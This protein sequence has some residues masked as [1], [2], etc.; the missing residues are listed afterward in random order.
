MPVDLLAHLH[1][2]EEHVRLMVKSYG[3]AHLNGGDFPRFSQDPFSLKDFR[4]TELRKFLPRLGVAVLFWLVGSYVNNVSQAWLQANMAG[5]YES[6]WGYS[7]ANFQDAQAWLKKNQPAVYH[8]RWHDTLPNE[9]IA[10]AP[11]AMQKYYQNETVTLFDLVFLYLPE[12]PSSGPADFFAGAPSAVGIIRFAVFPGPMSLRWTYL[13]RAIMVWGCLWYARAI[14]IIVTPLPN[15]Y[16]QCVPESPFPY[17]IWL[18]ALA[19]MPGAGLFGF[20]E[21]TCQDV[22]FSGHTAMGTTWTLF[23]WRYLKKAPWFRYTITHDWISLAVDAF[24]IIW[25]CGGWYVIAA[26]HFHYTVDVMVGAMFTFMIYNYYH[27]V[28]E[29]CWLKETHPFQ[30]SL[31]PFVTWLEKHSVDLK[32]WRASAQKLMDQRLHEHRWVSQSEAEP[33]NDTTIEVPLRDSDI[34]TP[35]V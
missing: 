15:P 22:M 17:S 14:T 5:F 9:T 23:N 28:I 30:R 26:A 33:D 21:L 6:E 19:N 2:E 24:C 16:K 35:V 20:H 4:P 18:E 31:A 1:D 32:H 8:D 13:T 10:D 27:N 12:V 34:A 25:L 3:C 7:K 29:T 11:K